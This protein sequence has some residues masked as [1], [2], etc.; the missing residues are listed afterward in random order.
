MTCDVTI[1]FFQSLETLIKPGLKTATSGKEWFVT[2]QTALSRVLKKVNTFLTIHNKTTYITKSKNCKL[3]EFIDGIDFQTLVRMCKNF[4]L[5][6]SHPFNLEWDCWKPI[7]KVMCLPLLGSDLS[8][9]S[10]VAVVTSL[11]WLVASVFSLPHLIFTKVYFSLYIENNYQ[12]CNA[13][14]SNKNIYFCD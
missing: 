14:I 9:L 4:Q 3:I 6:A 11:C 7:G 8:C 13:F 10:R 2:S 5:L 1:H 12:L